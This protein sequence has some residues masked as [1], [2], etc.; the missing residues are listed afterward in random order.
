M[1]LCFFMYPWSTVEPET[2]S[3]LRLVFEAALRGHTVVLAS[4]SH[5]TV[6]DNTICAFCQVIRKPSVARARATTFYNKV[7]FKKALLPLAGFDIIFMRENPQGPKTSLN[8]LDSI[9]SEVLVV[10]DPEGIRMGSNKLYSLSFTH[11]NRDYIPVTHV[12][13][14]REYLESV[15]AESKSS[16]M[17]MKPLVGYGGKGVILVE[18]KAI[19]NFRS[20]LDFYIDDNKPEQ[21][22]I[23]QEYIEGAQEG[24]VRIL[25][26]NGESIGAMKRRPNEKEHRANVHM[27]ATVEKHTLTPEEED[28]CRF[29]GPKL[30]RDGLYFVGVDVI[31]GK[32]IEINVCSPGGITRIN[33]LNKVQ[34]QKEVID[35]LENIVNTKELLANRKHLFKKAIEDVD[36][37]DSP[38]SK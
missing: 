12:S 1:K 36:S 35:F 8:F 37:Y 23:L 32:L 26:L 28:L 34:L 17:I 3:T 31:Q 18:K 22:V 24:D 20:L 2:D 4:S 33:R 13:R 6:R 29:I 15:L 14:S 38:D 19:Q 11:P 5:L 21:Y 25:M 30:I 9:K 10:N 16:K 7:E 27:G